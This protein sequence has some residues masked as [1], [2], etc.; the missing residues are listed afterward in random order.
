[1]T[2]TNN[3]KSRPYGLKKRQ[4]LI[5]LRSLSQ[6]KKTSFPVQLTHLIFGGGPSLSWG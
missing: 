1:M 5:Y 6:I 3:F 4:P 2:K